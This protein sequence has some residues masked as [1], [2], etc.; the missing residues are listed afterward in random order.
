MENAIVSLFCIALILTGTVTV[1]M[2]S[3][4]SVDSLSQSWKE[5]EDQAR[6]VRET[7]IVAVKAVVPDAYSGS[8][9]EITIRNDGEVS[10]ANFDRWDVIVHY[11]EGTVQWLPHGPST[12]GWTVGGIFF[13]GGPEAIEPDILNPDEEV[14]LILSLDPPVTQGAVNQATVSTPRGVI[15]SIMF[16]WEVP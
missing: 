4:S 10:L 12:P 9:V 14:L 11:E 13:G 16:K 7:E 3:F 2:S 8:R 6:Q 5:M 1:A 15:T